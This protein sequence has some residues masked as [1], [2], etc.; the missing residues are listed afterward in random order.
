MLE[1]QTMF[2]KRLELPMRLFLC[3]ISLLT[4]AAAATAQTMSIE[5]Y[6]PKSTLVV[7]EHIVTRAKYPFIDVH[8]HQRAA[9]PD[10]ADQLI[11]DMD[12]MNMAVMVNLSGGSGERL[13]QGIANLK[14]RYRDRF[15]VFANLDFS[16]ID[17]PNYGKRAAAQLEEDVKSGAQGLKI[18]K[19]L[20][21]ALRDGSGKRIP[22]DDPRFD[23]VWEACARLGIPVLIHTGEPWSFFQPV[24]KFNERWL[25]LKLH[26]NRVRPSDQFPAWEALIAEQHRLFQRHPKTT[27]INAHL[28]WL[29]S[30]LVQLGKLLDKCPNVQTE[31]GAVLYDLGRQPRFARAWLIRYQ[32]RVMFGKD[33]WA[34]SEYPTYFRVL[35]TADE[36]FDY[37]RKYHAFWQ[38][39]GLDLPDDVLQKLYYKNALRVIPGISRTQFEKS[40]SD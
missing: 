32:D 21:L 24:D 4:A 34:P 30:D 39:Y 19:N 3:A 12:A 15:V 35:E 33:A 17:D 22:V 11:R 23:P 36:Y 18:F 28:G 10:S 29:G 31:I 38:M 26:P 25:E 20:G 37:Y 7:P 16:G 40:K 2:L 13:K 5:E 9:S 1:Y 8:G 14:G 27:F 6:A